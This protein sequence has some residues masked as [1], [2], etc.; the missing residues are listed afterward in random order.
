VSTLIIPVVSVLLAGVVTMYAINI[1]STRTQQEALKLTKQAIWVYS[2]GTAIA[3][4]AIDNVGGRDVVLDKIQVRDV[5]TDWTSVYYLRRAS[6]VSASLICPNATHNWTNFLYT[7]DTV[8][9]FTTDG[10]E[11]VLASGNTMIV[12]I[13]YPDSVSVNDV[14]VTIGITIFTE[15]AQY[16]VET[17]VRSAEYA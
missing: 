17:N 9:N 15:N 3:A 1:T 11:K 2:N 14:G 10:Y 13:M 6:A 12:Y 5:E 7:I 8:A 16:Y 4:V